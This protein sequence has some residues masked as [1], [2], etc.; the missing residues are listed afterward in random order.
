[1]NVFLPKLLMPYATAFQRLSLSDTR[2]GV[3]IAK[4]TGLAA[5]KGAILDSIGSYGL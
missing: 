4:G 2:L 3:V 5:L 1:M